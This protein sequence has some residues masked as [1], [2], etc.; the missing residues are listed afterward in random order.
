MPKRKPRVSLP[1]G[2]DPEEWKKAVRLEASRRWLVPFVQYTFPDYH[3]SKAHKFVAEKLQEFEK[4]VRAKES[5]RL[6]LTL[7]PRFGKSELVSRRFPGW[8]LGRNPDWNVGIVS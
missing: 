5:P 3:V 1:P 7:P 4:A 2:V 8:V 6:I